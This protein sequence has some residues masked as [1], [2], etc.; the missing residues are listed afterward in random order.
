[1]QKEYGYYK[2]LDITKQ[3]LD[4]LNIKQFLTQGQT[5]TNIYDNIE[6]YLDDNDTR[7]AHIV[8]KFIKEHSD[9]FQG[10]IFNCMDEYEFMEYCQ[11]RYPEINWGH[12]IEEYYW[13]AN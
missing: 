8:N 2:E 3:A 5:L 4:L 11:K 1:M 6:Y 12:H 9:V 10:I 7:D 13:V